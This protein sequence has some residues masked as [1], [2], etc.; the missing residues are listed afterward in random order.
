MQVCKKICRKNISLFAAFFM[1]YGSSFAQSITPIQMPTMPQMPSMPTIGGDFYKP[2]FPVSPAAPGSK[3]TETKSEESKESTATK[4]NADDTEDL[5]TALTS[6]NSYLSAMDITSLYNSGLFDNISSLSNVNKKLASSSENAMLEQIIKSLEELKEKTNLSSQSQT[7][8]LK[9]AQTDSQTFK[10]RQPQ[11][12]R[13]RVN[14]YNI[15]DSLSTVFF[16]KLEDDGSFLL[17]AD[18]RYF[19][20]GR[21]RTETFY[22]LFKTIKNSGFSTVYQVEPNLVQ[23]YL[24]ENSFIYRISNIENLTAE[25]TGNLVVL[26][27]ADANLN[28]DLLLDIDQ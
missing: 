7:L 22:L 3:K 8:A 19:V 12:L 18:R 2:N 15:A 21:P 1:L 4:V 27:N 23:D 25:K 10:S 20:S 9:D 16:S 17:T 14:G 13:F 6:N 5:L 11:I 26:K 28:V 24:N